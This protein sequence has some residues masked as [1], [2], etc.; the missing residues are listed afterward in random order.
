MDLNLIPAIFCVLLC[1]WTFPPC[2]FQNEHHSRLKTHHLHHV[3]PFVICIDILSIAHSIKHNFDPLMV[4][5]NGNLIHDSHRMSAS[6]SCYNPL[7]FFDEGVYHIFW[8]EMWFCLTAEIFFLK[9]ILII[10]CWCRTASLWQRKKS[11]FWSCRRL[12]WLERELI[13]W[14]KENVSSAVV[15]LEGRNG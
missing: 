1:I 3:F 12:A 11:R 2:L 5:N 14:K 13:E 4:L 15:V 6:L 9:G 7:H 10:P 8:C